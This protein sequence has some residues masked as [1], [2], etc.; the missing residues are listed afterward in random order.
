MEK[1]TED[2]KKDGKSCLRGSRRFKL[3]QDF[4]MWVLKFYNEMVGKDINH[5]LPIY[6]TT[7]KITEFF[8]L[9]ADERAEE[10]M[11]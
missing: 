6:H 4:Q 3:G 1:I 2:I 11:N 8:N 9:I 5:H 7:R 10:M